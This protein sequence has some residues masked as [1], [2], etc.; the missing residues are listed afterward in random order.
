M[1][2]KPAGLTPRDLG[3]ESTAEF[4]HCR[5]KKEAKRVHGVLSATLSFLDLSKISNELLRQSVQTFKPERRAKW[6]TLER[7]SLVS[8][9]LS[10]TVAS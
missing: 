4:G 5:Y 2:L 8:H 10:A 7:R 3:Q 1:L 9:S 6:K